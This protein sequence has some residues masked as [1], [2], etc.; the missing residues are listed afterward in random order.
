MNATTLNLLKAEDIAIELFEE[1][2]ERQLIVAGKDEETLNKEIFELAKEL[3]SIEK[4]WHKRIVRSGANTLHPYKENPPNKIIQEDDILFFDFAWQETKEWF[5]TK[6]E[7]KAS[8]LFAYAENKAKE[9]NWEFGGEIAGHLIGEF[10]HERLDPNSYQ[11]YVH[12]DNHNNMFDL[13]AKG[14]K[15]NWILELHFVDNATQTQANSKKKN[16]LEFSTGYNFGYLKNLSFAPVTRYDYNG[17]NHQVKYTRTTK[18][19]KLFEVMK[20]LLDEDIYLNYQTKTDLELPFEEEWYVEVGGRTHAEGRHHFVARGERYAYDIQI[21]I[22]GRIRTG[23]GSKNE[24]HYCFGKRLNAPGAGKIVAVV[25]DIEDN[26]PG[27][28]NNQVAGNYII[29][30]HLNGESS[31]LVHLKKGTIIV[32]VGDTVE[33]GQEVGKAGNSGASSAPHLHYHLQTT[34]NTIRGL[35]LPAQ[36]QNYLKMA[37]L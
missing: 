34:T 6:T 11:L 15:R 14:Q 5:D 35:G 17:L 27:V 31:V 9:Y 33:K 26:Q 22:D 7:L 30:D 36:F 3:F 18:N 32:A 16:Q 4:H 2:E 25:N 21:E 37:C 24:D 23:D 19:D 10:P 20:G 28:T 1:A 29:I 8:E 12:P 13:N